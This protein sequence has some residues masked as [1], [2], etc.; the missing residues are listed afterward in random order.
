MYDPDASAISIDDWLE[1]ARRHYGDARALKAARRN[2]G[3]WMAS[4]FAVEAVLK[5]SI[6]AKERLNRWPDRNEAPELYTHDLRAL[7]QRL[8]ISPRTFDP[9]D[10]S[11][12]SW[13]VA[14]E[15]ERNHGYNVGKLPTR[16]ADSMYDAAFGA[17]GTIEW[18]AK[19]YRLNI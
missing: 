6:M 11:S 1:L 4:G 17:D 10:P 19:R 14:F 9:S 8:G 15:W 13:K 5:A 16:W 2:D 18:L 7:A 3:V 12:A